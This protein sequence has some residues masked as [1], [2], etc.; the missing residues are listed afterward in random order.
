[1]IAVFR[2]LRSL[3]RRTSD[4]ALCEANSF[5]SDAEGID[6]A[7]ANYINYTYFYSWPGGCIVWRDEYAEVKDSFGEVHFLM[8]VNIILSR[9]KQ[10]EIIFTLHFHIADIIVQLSHKIC[11]RGRHFRGN[12]RR[13]RSWALSIRGDTYDCGNNALTRDRGWKTHVLLLGD[14][15]E[16]H[17]TSRANVL[18]CMPTFGLSRYAGHYREYGN[19]KCTYARECKRSTA[20]RGTDFILGC[21]LFLKERL[22]QI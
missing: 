17:E 3:F 22:V 4:L 14:G 15:N 13:V 1:M 2:L 20:H 11:C 16:I 7:N 9:R 6:P 21:M 19:A 18:F 12:E 8:Q 5:A 10:N